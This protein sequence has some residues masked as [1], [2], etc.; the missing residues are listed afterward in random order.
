VI[1]LRPHQSE[2]LDAIISRLTLPPGAV[3]PARGL[4]GLFVS[5]T[6]TGKTVTAATAARRLVPNGRVG[7]M[8]PTLDLLAQTGLRPRPGS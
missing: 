1:K 4:R 3:L 2:A 8:V 7:W 6:G 5:A